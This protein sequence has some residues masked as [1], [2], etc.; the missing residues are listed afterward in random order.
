[1]TSSSGPIVKLAFAS[2]YLEKSD[3]TEQWFISY[4]RTRFDTN[5]GMPVSLNAKPEIFIGTLK[6][7][8]FIVIA[9]TT[10]ESDS[11][12]IQT[13]NKDIR[14]VADLLSKAALQG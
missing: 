1:M 9:Y 8:V 4:K 13:I 7:N 14:W 2:L 12:Y 11:D 3:A 5:H 6:K 10:Y